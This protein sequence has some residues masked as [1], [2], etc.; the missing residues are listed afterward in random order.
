MTVLH[1]EGQGSKSWVLPIWLTD[2]LGSVLRSSLFAKQLILQGVCV[3]VWVCVCVCVCVYLG[4]LRLCRSLAEPPTLLQQEDSVLGCLLPSLELGLRE[5]PSEHLLTSLAECWSSWH[6][7]LPSCLA[8][9]TL[10]HLG[11]LLMSPRHY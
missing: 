3:C 10:S 8:G 4:A 9:V 6:Q 11:L 7:N 1:E 5:M 2:H